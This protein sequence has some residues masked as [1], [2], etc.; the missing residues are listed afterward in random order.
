MKNAVKPVEAMGYAGI[1]SLKGL[2]ISR[3]WVLKALDVMG[4]R[5]RNQFPGPD[6]LAGHD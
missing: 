6:S 3:V 1:A 2:A 4:H 5:S